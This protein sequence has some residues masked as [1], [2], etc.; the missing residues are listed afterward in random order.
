MMKKWIKPVVFLIFLFVLAVFL[1]SK[2]VGLWETF[3]PRKIT[4]IVFAL[5][6]IQILGA[7]MPQLL[8]ARVGAVLA[9]FFG[10]LVS[11]TATTAS[12]ARKSKVSSQSD[13]AMETLTFLS[14]TL[15]MLF[16]G[17]AVVFWGTQ[18]FHYAL[19]L[20]FFG[21]ILLTATIIFLLSRKSTNEHLKT[22]SAPL[23]ILPILRL[24][25]FIIAILL[26]SKIL[27]KFFGQSGLIVLTFIVSLFEIHG[28]V[29]ANIQLHDAGVFNVQFLGSLLAISITASYLSKLFLIFTLGSSKLKSQAI[30][31]TS[32]LFL[33]LI[34]SWV[35]FLFFV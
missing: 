23:D 29:I 12:L 32:L 30:K 3:N 28:S 24:S 4:S 9:G 25:V 14:A 33:S 6:F 17:I 26:L 7:L 22:E 19:L 34:V 27:Q 21:P 35:V 16:E 2:P 10:G 1:P 11:S 8:G 5:A 13:P 18:D 15:A 31:Y 20:I